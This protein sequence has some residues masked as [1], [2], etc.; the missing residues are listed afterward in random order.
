MGS[1]QH[2][3]NKFAKSY[4]LVILM[5]QNVRYR[6]TRDAI[7]ITMGVREFVEY[8]FEGAQLK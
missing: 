3:K 2:L 8:Q 1:T 7:D 5:R 6:L 4:L